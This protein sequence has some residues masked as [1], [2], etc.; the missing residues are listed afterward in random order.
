MIRDVSAQAGLPL[1]S[2]RILGQAF[3]LV[4][5]ASDVLWSL[6]VARTGTAKLLSKRLNHAGRKAEGQVQRRSGY[7]TSYTDI[8]A[9]ALGD[10]WDCVVRAIPP[11]ITSRRVFVTAVSELWNLRIASADAINK[12]RKLYVPSAV[13]LPLNSDAQLTL[14]TLQE[15]LPAENRGD[16]VWSTQHRQFEIVLDNQPL[17]RMI[18]GKAY[19]SKGANYDIVSS[20][21]DLIES[22]LSKGWSPRCMV[23]DCAIWRRRCWNVLS[24]LAANIAVQRK[25][26]WTVKHPEFELKCRTPG[27]IIQL[28][29]DGA[30]KSTSNQGASAFTVT[31]CTLGDGGRLERELIF[32]SG[33][34]LSDSVSAFAAE[35]LAC[36]QAL[37]LLDAVSF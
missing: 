18:N 37:K 23:L 33:L 19:Y 7:R 26:N 13:D 17:S 14:E 32:V 8:F 21:V 12:K 15:F 3:N 24:D 36:Y 4:Y 29:S 1:I 28:H 25:S 6:F 16:S 27:A 10:D 5:N 9:Q 22:I 2:E 30:H 31:V 11:T 20:S 35:A 34:Y